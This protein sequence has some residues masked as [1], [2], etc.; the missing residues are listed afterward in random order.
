MKGIGSMLGI[1][2][3]ILLL[4]TGMSSS[5]LTDDNESISADQTA[6]SV[7]AGDTA[8]IHMIQ[9]ATGPVLATE[10]DEEFEG[11]WAFNTEGGYDDD[12]FD[13]YDIGSGP[14]DIG[15]GPI[16]IGYDPFGIGTGGYDPYNTGVYGP[17]P[18]IFPVSK[19]GISIPPILD[20]TQG[21]GSVPG[22]YTD[23]I[24]AFGQLFKNYPV[25]PKKPPVKT[26]T[27]S[28]VPQPSGFDCVLGI[29]DCTGYQIYCQPNYVIH[30]ED[31]GMW[32]A[33]CCGNYHNPFGRY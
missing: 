11:S 13:P 7:K 3:I 1:T 28:P 33:R 14:M 26:P 27:T 32:K 15:S 2:V 5:G 9:M 23:V 20:I 21:L 16:D 31:A 25:K 22:G 4:L 12:W 18:S 30:H 29:C 24:D 10:T 6:S 19:S 8:I 17:E